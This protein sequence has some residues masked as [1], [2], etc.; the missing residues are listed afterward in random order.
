MRID[1]QKCVACGNCLV[2]CPVSAISIDPTIRRATV[3]SA[4]LLV[5]SPSH[6]IV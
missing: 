6:W 3:P 4:S 2:V 1:P 5:L